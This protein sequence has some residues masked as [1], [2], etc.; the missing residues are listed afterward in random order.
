MLG[1]GKSTKH[2]GLLRQLNASR[3]MDKE[4]NADMGGTNVVLLG[5]LAMRGSDAIHST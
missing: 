1:L 3:R 2:H 5:D 4:E